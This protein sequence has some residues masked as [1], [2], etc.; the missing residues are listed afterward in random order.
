M[1]Y[2][3]INHVKP[4]D[5]LAYP[6]TNNNKILLQQNIILNDFYINRLKS[7][8]YSGIYIHDPLSEGIMINNN[9]P[10]DLKITAAKASADIDV[11]KCMVLSKDIIDCLYNE[12]YQIKTSID[13]IGDYDSMT[14]MHSTNV[15]IYSGMLGILIGYSQE[16]LKNLV[17][18]ALLHDIGKTQIDIKILNKHRKLSKEERKI[19]NL[20]PKIGYDLL[21]NNE[22]VP[23][24]VRVAVLQHH[25]NYNGT[26]YPTGLSKND[27]HE[28]AQIIH[29]CDVYDAMIS[30]RPYKK[31]IFST[32]VVE[33][34][35]SQS[36]F[37]FNPSL[38]EQ[39]CRHLIVFPE[40]SNVLLSDKT[41]AF[42]KKNNV[43]YPMR[44]IVIDLKTKQ[45]INLMEKTNITITKIL[46]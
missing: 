17:L 41:E 20:H 30:R 36:G 31:A 32:D 28:F 27:I 39:F 38:T 13:M 8:G 35:M 6:I 34:I 43:K 45:E 25:E 1:R 22:D 21:K 26:G 33:Y 5:I 11:S 16:K 18:A 19:I 14:Y 15:S 37:M 42:V 10:L 12:N 3:T 7:L 46:V 44:P 2:E 9:I 24:V 4:G 23:S 40:G 29:I